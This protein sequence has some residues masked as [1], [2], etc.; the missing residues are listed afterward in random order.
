MITDL[1]FRIS[2]PLEPSAFNQEELSDVVRDLCLSK[3]QSD[4]LESRL[5]QKALFCPDTKVTFYRKK[6]TKRKGLQS[7]S[8]RKSIQAEWDAVITY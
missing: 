7:S 3:Q 4:V 8:I 1:D 5:Q 6:K 2:T